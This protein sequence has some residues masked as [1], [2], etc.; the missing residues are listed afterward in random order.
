VTNLVANFVPNN[1]SRVARDKLAALHQRSG[2]ADY[3]REFRMVAL[4]IPDMNESEKLDR[5]TRGLKPFLRKEV[6]LKEPNRLDDAI[7]LVTKL[8]AATYSAYNS[9]R[10]SD[11]SSAGH[12]SDSTSSEGGADGC[13]PMELNAANS[14]RS[15]TPPTSQFQKLTPEMRAQLL[16]EGKCLY[17]RKPGH[18]RVD[19]PTRPP[20]PPRGG[21]K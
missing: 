21:P 6:L 18:L 16:A 1:A 12:N 15:T 7:Q 19:C 5:F 9:H 14:S 13:A 2:V 3:I 17:C 10:S 8:D 11:S 20:F 4:D